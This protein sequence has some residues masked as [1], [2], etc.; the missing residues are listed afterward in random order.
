MISSSMGGL[1]HIFNL[2]Q[3]LAN[4]SR[5]LKVGGRAIHDLTCTNYV[6]FGF[7]CISPIALIQY[8]E[9]NGFRINGIN[10][11]G[12]DNPRCR[13]VNIISPDCRFNNSEAWV[14]SCADGYRILLVCDAEK[15]EDRDDYNLDF[16]Q[17]IF[18]DLWEY[19]KAPLVT[20]AKKKAERAINRLRSI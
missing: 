2:P 18:N 10:M 8:Y 9:A 7:W 19:R 5:M 15:T 11:M 14:K 17:K 16:P 4:M 13:D 6:D 20:R 12:Y 3:A 1:Q